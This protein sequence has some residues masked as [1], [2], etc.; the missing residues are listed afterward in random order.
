MLPSLLLLHLYE[1]CQGKYLQA[2][3]F[4]SIAGV[5]LVQTLDRLTACSVTQKES[6][7]ICVITLLRIKGNALYNPQATSRQIPVAKPNVFT[8]LWN[9]LIPNRYIH[10]QRMNSTKE[11]KK[12]HNRG[13]HNSIFPCLRA[14]SP[15]GEFVTSS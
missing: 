14:T 4:F 5:V 8:S 12:S 9:L 2:Y 3:P 1:L 7:W 11:K 10:L 6:E 15:A 13:N